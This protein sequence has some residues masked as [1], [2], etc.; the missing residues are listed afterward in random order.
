MPPRLFPRRRA[1]P[2]AAVRPGPSPFVG[3]A[4]RK[5]ETAAEQP[6]FAPQGRN[7]FYLAAQARLGLEN[8]DEK[9]DGAARINAVVRRLPQ[10]ENVLRAERGTPYGFS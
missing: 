2:Q 6:L 5:G 4:G 7:G 9:A 3:H 10:Q 1:A 8:A